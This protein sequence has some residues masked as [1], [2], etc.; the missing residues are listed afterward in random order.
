MPFLFLQRNYIVQGSGK[1]ANHALS[2]ILSTWCWSVGAYTPAI[3]ASGKKM[4]EGH[5]F[6]VVFGYKAS[7]RPTW[8]A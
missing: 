3:P 1:V 8:P 5:K 4:Q 7:S 2:S 6:K